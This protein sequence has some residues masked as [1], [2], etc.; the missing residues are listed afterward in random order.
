MHRAS[1]NQS[2]SRALYKKLFDFPK[3]FLK[4]I[5]FNSVFTKRL[6]FDEFIK[7]NKYKNIATN[8][9]ERKGYTFKREFQLIRFPTVPT[10][11]SKNLHNFH[12]EITNSFRHARE[13]LQRKKRRKK[14]RKIIE[15]RSGEC[16]AT[17]EIL[18]ESNKTIA[19]NFR[20]R[21]NQVIRGSSRP[22]LPVGRPC[23]P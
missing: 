5:N 12:A 18:M 20:V 22:S 16:I 11:Q 17:Y 3:I 4:D 14:K 13:N 1:E 6:R 21:A 7:I 8:G 19:N 2:F 23:V 10:S 15:V 9:V